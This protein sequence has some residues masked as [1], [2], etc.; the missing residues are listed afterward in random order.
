[1][2]WRV[3]FGIFCTVLHQSMI[4]PINLGF[5]FNEKIWDFFEQSFS[6]KF[7]TQID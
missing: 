5:E 1:M 4:A 6:W 7:D 2:E 3:F